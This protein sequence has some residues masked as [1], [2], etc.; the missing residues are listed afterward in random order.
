MLPDLAGKRAFVEITNRVHGGHGWGFGTCLW[1]PV[2]NRAGGRSWEIMKEVQSGDLIIH[3]LDTD[4]GYCWVGVSQ[5]QSSAIEIPDEPPEP[6]KWGNM[7]PYY[8]IPL[9]QFIQLEEPVNVKQI[10]SDYLERLLEILETTNKGLFYV[11]YRN[12]L[13]VAQRYLAEVPD[14]LYN[15]FKEIASNIGFKYDPVNDDIL[16]PT[17]SEPAQVD[18]TTPGRVQTLLSRIVRDTQLIRNL[19]S[20]CNY[21]CQICGNTIVL[22]NGKKYAEGHHLRPLGSPYN[23]PDIEQNIIILCPTH[24]AEFDY[25]SIAIEPNTKKIVH[26]DVNNIYHLKELAY[27]REDLDI[28]FI[29]Y[30]YENIFARK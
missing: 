9:N 27:Q 8:R 6:G 25:G 1:S 11:K 4:E 19:K 13:R 16:C 12:E 14:P 17:S 5:A 30:H 24:H 28:E 18:I 15:I 2:R 21:L 7:S 26:I 3:L 22:P 20:S 29:R 23:G 10:F